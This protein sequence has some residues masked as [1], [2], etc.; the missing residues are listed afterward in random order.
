MPRGWVKPSA[1][2]KKQKKQAAAPKYFAPPTLAPPKKKQAPVRS[3]AVAQREGGVGKK[4]HRPSKVLPAFELGKPGPHGSEESF[5]IPTFHFKKALKGQPSWAWGRATGVG[6]GKELKVARKAAVRFA[7]THPQIDKDKALNEIFKKRHESELALARGDL[8]GYHK[9]EKKFQEHHKKLVKAGVL[10]PPKKGVL[11][12]GAR[13]EQNIQDAAIYAP[14]GLIGT[15]KAAALDEWDMA[16]HGKAPTRIPALAKA[17]GQQT[18]GDIQHPLRNP[19]NL[20]LDAVAIASLGAGSAA[21]VGAAG[22]AFKAAGRLGEAERAL[23][24]A[25][26]AAGPYRIPK[27]Q[28]GAGKF[29]KRPPPEPVKAPTL[30]ARTKAALFRPSHEGGSLLNRPAARE[31]KLYMQRPWEGEG[32]MKPAGWDARN[33]VVVA[34][35]LQPDNPLWRP[36]HNY[37]TKKLQQHLDD[38]ADGKKSPWEGTHFERQAKITRDLLGMNAPKVVGREH[39]ALKRID[40]DLPKEIETVIP[41]EWIMQDKPGPPGEIIKRARKVTGQMR[42]FGVYLGPK[43]ITTNLAG[44]VIMSVATQGVA[45]T[46]ANMYRAR[47]MAKT[48][49]MDFTKAVEKEMGISRTGSYDPAIIKGEREGFLPGVSTEDH[50][51]VIPGM[52]EHAPTPLEAG[53]AGWQDRWTNRMMRITDVDYRKASWQYR[54]RERGFRTP[55]Q[56]HD[57]LNNPKHAA[58]RAAVAR[59]ARKDAVDYDSLSP[60]EKEAADYLYFYPWMSRAT[61]WTGRTIANR[62]VKSAFL[63][64]QGQQGK[65]M[66]GKELGLQPE[67]MKG[68]IK[69]PWGV[70]NPKSTFP[71]TTPG[72]ILMQG[73]HVVRGSLGLDP[74]E[75]AGGLASLAT[76]F[77]TPAFEAA[78]GGT[79]IPKMV[80]STLPLSTYVRAG[81]PLGKVPGTSV[82]KTFPKT[83][84]KEAAG[85]VF[86]GG[87]APRHAVGEVYHG[88]AKRE[89]Y[90]EASAMQRIG[91]KTQEKKSAIPNEYKMLKKQGLASQADV[92]AYKGD[93]DALQHMKEFQLRFAKSKGKNSYRQLKDGQKRQAA[94]AYLIKYSHFSKDETQGFEFLS[95][96]DV[97]NMTGI[98]QYD[99]SW[100]AN[101]KTAK[102]IRKYAP[103]G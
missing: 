40:E 32:G 37:R 55:K 7:K 24:A 10:A 72:D 90:H 83:G 85:P 30:G 33:R 41:K 73:R 18:W 71:T 4:P 65:K 70:V 12:F 63:A 89:L 53:K 42:F 48:H 43:Y 92:A 2:A 87:W 66:S 39:R 95:P 62:P 99:K 98:G 96:T 58:D 31:T 35:R 28:P 93:L 86:L 47:R 25:G 34:R 1:P 88:Q 13:F 38:L 17:M 49:G 94:I 44:N 64:A 101:L 52:E 75:A 82:A 97:W 84:I 26:E 46:A 61:V 45:K 69:T 91:M 56:Q 50:P 51:A 76:E 102:E 27:G 60:I 20:A 29:G 100:K 59:R 68:Y 81:S 9:A 57:L 15:G 19:G 3:K 8:K 6:P 54:A 16:V 103:K 14:Y 23:Q 11:G 21:K 80:Q 79:S 78:A 77:G 74:G 22:S 5:G 67:W 36:A